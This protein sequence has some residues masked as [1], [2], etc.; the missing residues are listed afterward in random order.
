[1]P[2]IDHVQKR[3]RKGLD[4]R[5]T[6]EKFGVVAST[7]CKKVNTAGF[8]EN[9]FRLVPMFRHGSRTLL[10]VLGHQQKAM[11]RLVHLL[12]S[13]WALVG[14]IISARAPC[15]GTVT[16]SERGLAVYY[17][18]TELCSIN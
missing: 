18:Q 13:L 14:L 3:P 10:V 11:F 8:E 7:A 17:A 2:W 15:L 16:K 1:M 4:Y 9:L 6:G 12:V 5:E